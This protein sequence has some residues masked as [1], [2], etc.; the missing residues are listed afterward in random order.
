MPGFAVP[1]DLIIFLLAAFIGALVAGL[2]GFAFGPNR[3]GNLAA[4]NR[5]C[6]ECG[7]DRRFGAGACCTARVNSW[8]LFPSKL[9]ETAEALRKPTKGAMAKL[10][11]PCRL[12]DMRIRLRRCTVRAGVV[13]G[14]RKF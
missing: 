4:R 7:T 2:A 6:R 14:R 1:L 3:I 8:H 9:P 12:V 5:A 10:N 11:S 13:V